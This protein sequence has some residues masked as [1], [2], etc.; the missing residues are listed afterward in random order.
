MKARYR[1]LF[2]LCYAWV[3][4]NA[5]ALKELVDY[6]DWLNNK[7]KTTSKKKAFLNRERKKCLKCEKELIKNDLYFYKNPNTKDGFTT[8]CKR[9]YLQRKKECYD[10]KRDKNKK[11]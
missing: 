7:R 3:G 10:A 1:T 9:C 2:E 6:L 4:Y 11:N 8:F 5:L